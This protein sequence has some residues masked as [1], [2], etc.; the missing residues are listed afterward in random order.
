MIASLTQLLIRQRHWLFVISLLVC[1][2]AMSGL[3]HVAFDADPERYFT[4]A[5]PHLALLREQQALYGSS[6][7]LLL[8]L[9]SGNTP[10]FSQAGLSLLETLH[11]RAGQLPYASRV[12]S[13]FNYPYSRAL[14]HTLIIEPLVENYSR[15][16]ANEL[17]ARQLIAA[18]Q[19]A[20]AGRLVS[21]DGQL[22]MVVVTAELP[23]DDV[24]RSSRLLYRQ[25]SALADELQQRHPGVD[26]LISGRVANRAVTHQLAVD[27]TLRLT[28]LMYGV[29]FV[30]LW[31]WLRSFFAML[32]IMLLTTL[33][34]LASLGLAMHAGIVLNLLSM[35]AGN[36]I[37]TLSI[38]HCVHIVLAFLQRYRNGQ[39]R[40]S[41]LQSSL[42]LNLK[43]VFI[44]SA[45]TFIGF[46]S[47]NLSD[48]PPAHD[49]GNITALGVGFAFILSLSLLPWLLLI[50]PISR[51]HGDIMLR[52]PQR[53]AQLADWIIARPRQLLAGCLLVSLLLALCLPRNEINDRFTDNIREP[54]PFRSD[55]QR[56]DA[57]FGGLYQLQY[58]L[59]AP[60][61]RTVSDAGYLAALDSLASWLRQQPEVRHVFAYSDVL[62]QLNR[63][64]HNDEAAADRVPASNALA[65]QYLLL[66]EVSQAAED[67]Q[68]YLSAERDASKLLVSLAS[69]DSR[70]LIA[71]EQRTADYMRQ[72]LPV[73]MRAEAT[74]LA[75]MWAYLGESVL[76]GSLYSALFALLLISLVLLLLFRSWKYGLL[77]LVPNLLPAVVG[78]GF[79]GLYSGALDLGQ[80]MVLTLTT[81]IVVDDT[82]HLLS[83]YLDARQSGHDAPAALKQ[84]FVNSGAAL[85]ITT[86]VLVTGFALLTL[87]GFAPTAHLGLL[88]AIILAAALAF[89]LLLLPALL[90]WLDCRRPAQKT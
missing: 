53:M 83:K 66:L 56:I 90:W 19:P 45:T 65:A 46:A 75:L 81:G 33:S 40:I 24:V 62:R 72:N 6:D 7:T 29:I 70:Q 25:A 87:S 2:L 68:H 14:E 16:S 38:A 57:Q 30:L 32:S 60:A 85:L 11:Q 82:V 44:T 55:N 50:L 27:E 51:Q 54:H 8:V 58:S 1:V 63:S 71:L 12:D 3:R 28:P 61:G 43:P 22:A 17:A 79:W 26:V 41:A 35:T 13:L 42:Q 10:L 37:I 89:D 39:D 73:S 88:T 20:I 84:M 59:P 78:Y 34:C 86:V 69:L 4:G 52:Y 47:M 9:D 80:M 64:M 36:I 21:T 48:M 76:L 23:E 77:S 18:S 74:S 49:L 5:N 15:L 67:M 31:W